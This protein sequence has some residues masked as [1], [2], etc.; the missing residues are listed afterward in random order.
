M[1]SVVIAVDVGGTTIK[2]A[3]VD[4]GGEVVHAQRRSTDAGRGPDAVTATVVATAAE[5]AD[6]ARENGHTPV[7]CGL[8]TPGVVDESAGVAVFSANL[9]LRDVPLRELVAARTGLPTALGHDVRAGALAEARIG[10]GLGTRRMFFVAL[11]TGIAGAFA[12]DGRV[13]PGAHGGS[14]EIGHVVIR[15][16]AGSRPC[17]CGGRGCLERYASA[18]AVAAA[19]GEPGVEAAEVVRRA[20]AG[21]ERAAAV[22]QEAVE[23]LADGLLVGIA[24]FDPQVVVLGGGLAQ[25]GQLL[26]AP[27][28]KELV[29]RRT[30]HQLPALAVAQL[31]DEAGMRGAALLALDALPEASGERRRASSAHGPTSPEGAP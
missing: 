14:G 7:A 12:I 30:F 28:E 13:D 26:L 6:L 4:P 23:A 11:G 10:A 3:L 8:V 18:A 31:G 29:R 9:G 2:C 27:L 17:G 5:L 15:T 21:D 20:H 22:W 19:Y 24:L 25:A 1:D 16:Q